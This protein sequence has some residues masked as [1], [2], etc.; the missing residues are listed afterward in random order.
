MT[1][2]FVSTRPAGRDG[3][4]IYL[5]AFLV[6]LVGVLLGGCASG[7]PVADVPTSHS[8]DGAIASAPP[9]ADDQDQD[10]D[11]DPLEPVNRAIY[12]FNSAFDRFLLK[13]VARGYDAVTPDAVQHSIGRFFK[14][15]LTPAV[16]LN[17]LLQGKP[18]DSASDVGRFLVNS[19]IG[20][21][22][23]FDPASSFGLNAHDEDFGQTL[24]VWGVGDGPYLVLPVLGPSNVRDGVG[25]VGDFMTD[26]VSYVDDRAARWGLWAI[27]FVDR[28]A[29]LLGASSVLEQAGG[30]DEY[31]FVRE[32]YR[33]RR[34]YLIY[35]GAPPKPK[36]FDE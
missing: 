13:P 32:A 9:A 14:N 17:N 4:H 6:A 33:Q 5:Y 27:Y 36:F 28:R 12:K 29:Q 15:L 7:G 16:G 1:R 21:L 30:Q 2:L 11:H 25:L 23:L 19:T 22:G 24:G 34:Q 31:L 3:V 10:D 35:D 20:V 8:G 26:P 18:R